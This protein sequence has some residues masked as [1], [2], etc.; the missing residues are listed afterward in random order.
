MPSFIVKQKQKEESH[1]PP[2]KPHT[3][4]QKSIP[5]ST[6]P[7]QV[8][9]KKHASQ[10]AKLKPALVP[11]EA[12]NHVIK[13]DTTKH[14]RPETCLDKVEQKDIDARRASTAYQSVRRQNRRNGGHHRPTSS[15]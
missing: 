5:T 13:V 2:K 9:S 15:Y 8:T 10:P 6:Q 12:A 14:A 11:S 4:I 1:R 3:V 7:S